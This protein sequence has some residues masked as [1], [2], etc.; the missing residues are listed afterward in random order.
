M[1][2]LGCFSAVGQHY[3]SWAASAL[4]CH[5][6]AAIQL[7]YWS[8]LCC[9]GTVMVHCHRLA[10]LPPLCC[11]TTVRLHCHCYAALPILCCITAV[12]PHCH[13]WATWPLLRCMLLLCCLP[14][15]CSLATVVLLGHL[16][17]VL[18]LSLVA[19]H[20]M[21][22]SS[23]AH[24]ACYSFCLTSYL[25]ANYVLSRVLF[26]LLSHALHTGLP[27]MLFIPSL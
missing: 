23:A 1:P 9:M 8:L 27:T 6:A 15:S 21:C 22:Y 25:S 16:H 11:N 4:L 17:A 5:I 19:C 13:C 2:L 10:A 26:V 24:S 14:L 12:I 3:H 7:H 20:C 18:P